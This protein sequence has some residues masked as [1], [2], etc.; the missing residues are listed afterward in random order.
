M[1]IFAIEAS[2]DETAVAIN[3]DGRLLSSITHSQVQHHAQH[4]GVVPELATRLHLRCFNTVA[5]AALKKAQVNWSEIHYIA[6]TSEPGLIGCLNITHV[7]AQVLGFILQRPTIGVNHLFAHLYANNIVRSTLMFPLLGLVVSGG[8]TH[9][10]YLQQSLDFQ[11]IGQSQDDA[12]G[13]CLDK[14]GR[15]LGL[16][17]PAGAVIEKLAREG[18]HQFKF[19]LPKTQSPL[20][21]SFSGLKTAC[22]QQISQLSGVQHNPVQLA[23]F[24]CSL[25]TTVVQILTSRL[26]LALQ[27]FRVQMIALGGGVAANKQLRKAL[28]KIARS[29]H[30]QLAMPPVQFCTD[31]A[32]MVAILA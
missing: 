27:S 2:C 10:Y 11:L 4:G 31:N 28:Q 29:H 15:L 17:Y 5:R 3:Q 32:A 9:L 12:A 30:L 19:S 20:N 25:Q 6:Y 21:F 18:R 7:F 1:I 13:E 24:C 26:R 14:V 16:K 8:H 22:V 23:N